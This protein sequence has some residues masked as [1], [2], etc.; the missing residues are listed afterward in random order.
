MLQDGVLLRIYIAESMTIRETP[1][2]RFLVQYFLNHGMFGCTVYRGM[3]GFGHKNEI[4]TVDVLQFSF[5]LPVIIDVVDSRDKIM[6]VLPEVE[7]LIEDGMITL[8][9]VQMIRKVP[10][11]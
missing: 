4:R 9:D 3:G 7:T 1:G 5:D 11:E 2:Y 6:A 10:Q 8:Q